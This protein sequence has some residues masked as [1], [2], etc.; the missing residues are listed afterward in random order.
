MFYGLTPLGTVHTAISLVA[1]I[2]GLIAFFRYREISMNNRA[3]RVY[4]IATV[5][6]CL[7]GFGIFQHGGFG[8]P[9]ALGIITLV[10]LAVAWQAGRSSIF[11]KLS[12][13]VAMVSYSLT[14]FFHMIPGATETATRLPLGAPWVADPDAS[15]ALQAVIG[16]VFVVFLIGATLQVLR[17]RAASTESPADALRVMG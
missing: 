3:G 11:G 7:T 5:L 12:P 8:K 15:P 4:V 17:L 6:T 2:A 16:G 14:F 9:H 10:V 13:Y 1:V